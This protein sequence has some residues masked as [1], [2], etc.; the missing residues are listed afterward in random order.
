MLLA[1]NADRV[2]AMTFAE[3]PSLASV[4]G[5]LE[6]YALEDL[7]EAAHRLALEFDLVP[8]LG[9][10]GYQGMAIVDGRPE[11]DLV[12]ALDHSAEFGLSRQ[13]ASDEIQHVRAGIGG[14]RSVFEA[15]GADAQIIRRVDHCFSQ[16]ARLIGT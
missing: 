13:Q 7:A 4:N 9:N 12:L 10:L 14:W 8:Q 5:L 2:G 15:T 16:Q 11:S 1:T 3:S 6:R